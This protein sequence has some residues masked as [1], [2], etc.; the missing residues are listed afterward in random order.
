M[1]KHFEHL[2]EESEAVVTKWYNDQG[3]DNINVPGDL[4]DL[5]KKFVCMP[6]MTSDEKEDLMGEILITLCY[7]SKKHDINTYAVLKEA[8]NNLKVEMLDP[9]IEL[10]V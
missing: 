7:L 10:D 4:E 8:M 6:S 1:I 2:W 3:E 5:A 9:D